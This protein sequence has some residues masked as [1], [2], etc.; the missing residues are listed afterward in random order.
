M[1]DTL[2]FIYY[3]YVAF[4]LA[5]VISFMRYVGRGF[6]YSSLSSQFL[7]NRNLFYG[8]VPWHYGIIA[9]LT[10][11]LVVF[12]IPGS[13]L[14][15]NRVPWRLYALELTGLTLALFALVGLLN[16]IVRRLGNARIR[17]VT[18]PMD[19]ILLALLLLQVGLGVETA[20]F[21]RWGSSW[22]AVSAVPYLRSLVLLHP[23]ITQVAVWPLTI[24]L[25]VI[26]AFTLV[27]IFP[28]TR[29]VHLLVLPLHYLWRPYQKVVWNWDRRR[30]QKA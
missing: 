22:Y 30:S 18:S 25:H 15:F 5:V 13:L 27:A 26:G 24:K 7:E 10:G 4:I 16:L 12:F 17:A 23:D 11:H 21:Y 1:H 29:L 9:V 14:E 19:L 28:F 2:L 3:P 20:I 6:S 8:S